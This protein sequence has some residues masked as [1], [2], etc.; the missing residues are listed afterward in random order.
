MVPMTPDA[1]VAQMAYLQDQN[2]ITSDAIHNAENAYK[3]AYQSYQT[4]G[5]DLK[6]LIQ[7]EAFMYS[8]IAIIIIIVL[9]YVKRNQWYLY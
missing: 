1:A 4:M 2:R 6:K 3:A 5:D 9:L 7:S 8:F